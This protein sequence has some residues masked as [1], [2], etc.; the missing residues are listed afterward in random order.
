MDQSKLLNQNLSPNTNVLHSLSNSFNNSIYRQLSIRKKLN[1]PSKSEIN[2]EEDLDEKQ[3]QQVNLIKSQSERASSYTASSNSSTSSST[4]FEEIAAASTSLLKSTKCKESIKNP[5]DNHNNKNNSIE[6]DDNE[7]ENSML[8]NAKIESKRTVNSTN[9][10][11]YPGNMSSFQSFSTY[12]SSVLL[13]HDR[14]TTSI[15]KLELKF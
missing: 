14:I 11:T 4:P 7:N 13:N 9:N 2:E 10:L 1:K 12:S 15:H 8:N 6:F 3:L 5:D